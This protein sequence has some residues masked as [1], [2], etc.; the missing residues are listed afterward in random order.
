MLECGST[1]NCAG[2]TLNY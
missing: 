2:Y 1:T